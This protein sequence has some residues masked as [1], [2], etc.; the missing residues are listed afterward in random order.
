MH[1]HDPRP[2][3]H[4]N[5]HTL[6]MT[7]TRPTPSRPGGGRRRSRGAK[8][9]RGKAP[10]PPPPSDPHAPDLGTITLATPIVTLLP[11]WAH[12]LFTPGLERDIEQR[13][14][15]KEEWGEEKWMVV[16][17]GAKPPTREDLEY[18]RKNKGDTN[19][20][21]LG[22]EIRR[23]NIEGMVLYQ[24]PDPKQESKWGFNRAYGIKVWRVKRALRFNGA[25][26]DMLW[27]LQGP[28]KPLQSY[29][30][31]RGS[32]EKVISGLKRRLRYHEYDWIQ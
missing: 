12:C 31:N 5:L 28:P 27:G 22:A 24:R 3:R 7:K 8:R 18:I 30:P 19:G 14:G 1:E 17:S 23:S 20:L 10:P 26:R 32:P 2:R 6:G 4:P 13:G 25:F 11:I 29:A 9:R 21:T 16:L 15:W